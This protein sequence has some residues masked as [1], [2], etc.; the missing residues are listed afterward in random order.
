[1]EQA[2]ELACDLVAAGKDVRDKISEA[3]SKVEDPK[4]ISAWADSIT[5][6]AVDS[7]TKIEFWLPMATTPKLS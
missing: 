7:M 4:G 2:I 3:L 1:M 6:T 5:T